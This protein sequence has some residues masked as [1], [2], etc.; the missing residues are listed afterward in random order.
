MLREGQARRPHGRARGDQER[1]SPMVEILTPQGIEEMESQPQGPASRTS[2]PKKTKKTARRRS[3]RRSRCSTQEEASKLVDMEVVTTRGHPARRAV[4]HRLPRRD[5]QDRR[6]RGHARPRRLARGRA[7]RPAADRRGLDGQHEVRHG[8]D[9]PHPVHR[10]GRVPHREAVRPDPGAPGPLP[11]PR[12]AR[13]AD[14]RRLRPHPHRAEERARQAVRRAAW[15]PR[16]SGSRSPTTRSTRSRAIA[17]AVNERTENI[18]ARRLHTVLERLLDELS[19]DAPEI[20]GARGRRSTRRTCATKLEDDRRGRGS[21]ALHPLATRVGERRRP[22]GSRRFVFA[23]DIRFS[24]GD[25][26]RGRVI[27]SALMRDRIEKAEVL[28]EALPYIRRFSGKTIVI[29]YGGHAMANDELKE[30]FAQDIVLLKY[31]GMNPVIVHGGGPQID[32]MLETAGRRVEVRPRH[33]GHRRADDGRRRDGAGRQDQQGDRRPDQPA[34]R[35]RRRP[36][37][38]GRR[39]D[40]G[41]EAT[42]DADRRADQWTSGSSARSSAINPR[43]IESLDRRRLHP[44]DRAGRRRPSTARPTTSTP[45]SS[46]ARSRRR[47][48]PRS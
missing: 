35:T 6:P 10:R 8:A 34:R 26:L 31:V 7:A 11:D 24:D 43:V 18:G 19:F 25:R 22:D 13:A 14:A 27:H 3:P 2:C 39:A 12:R 21:L 32:S 16:A 48:T 38:Q 30:S 5:R 20:G 29:K 23:F 44:G 40:L 47:C 1:P 4:G 36:L 33:A 37:G 9:R 15:R 42:E 41:Q 45:T 28:L 46:P 17:A